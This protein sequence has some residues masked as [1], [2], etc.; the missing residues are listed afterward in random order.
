MTTHALFQCMAQGSCGQNQTKVVIIGSHHFRMVKQGGWAGGEGI[1]ASSTIQA[2][3]NMGYS[4]LFSSSTDRTVQL[5]HIFQDLVKLII[6]EAEESI[7]MWEHD[8]VKTAENPS[9]VPGWLIFSFAFWQWIANPM[10]PKWTLNPEDYKLMGNAPNT[11]LGYSIEAQCAKI[12][13][14]PHSERN[15]EAWIMAKAISYFHPNVRAWDPEDFDAAAESAG[16]SFLT[17]AGHPIPQHDVRVEEIVLSTSIK[18]LGQQPQEQFHTMLSKTR[19]LI[20]MGD[21]VL[22]PSPYDA[23]CLGVPFINPIKNWNRD[24]PEDRGSW[25]SQHNM[26]KHLSPPYVY[27]VFKGDRA[28]FVQAVKDAVENPI[29]SYVLDRMRMSAVEQ[30]LG[31]ILEHDWRLE[32]AEVLRQRKATRQGKTFVL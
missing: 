26:L 27:H 1:W 4:V 11:Y 3:N 18:N 21:P 30:R 28:G 23:L 17:G 2:L 19:V 9:G 13:F 32:A 15:R 16:I 6:V 12:P 10:G 22:S 5:Y 20:G 7:Y 29:Q 31:R 24:H 14:V 25:D 8:I